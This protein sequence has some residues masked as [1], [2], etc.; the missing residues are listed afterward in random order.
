[1]TSTTPRHEPI[2]I[3]GMACR[4][5]GGRTP[6]EFW[7]FL[8]RGGDG[9]GDIPPERWDSAA[10][11]D[12]DPGVPGKM[13]VK[14]GAFLDDF[15]LFAPGFFGISPR[16][17]QF[18]D[19]QQRLLL[20]VHW[21]A[22]E[23]AGVVPERLAQQQVGVF[24]GIGTSDYNELQ[25]VLGPKGSDAYSGTGGSHAA[26]A[27]R[28]S[29]I[30]GVRG[31]S[32]AVD[33]AC[34]SSLVSVHLA[35][36]S[37][38]GGESDLALASGVTLNF[39]PDVFISLCKARMLS[40]D[41]C[42]KTFDAKANGYARG[43]GCGV[44]V[45]KRLSD[46]Q[47]DGDQILALIRGSAVNHNGRSSGL[48]VPSGP[49]QQEVI[50]TALRN[51]GVDPAEI[52]YVEAH[53]T[54]TALGDP[55]ELNAL[56]AVFAGRSDPL[57]I[58]SV[59]TNTGHLEWAAGAC[60]LTKLVMSMRDGR[61]A[62]SL[63]FDDPNPLIAWDRLPLRVVKETTAWPEGRR[64][65]GV[66]SFGFGGTNAHLVLEAAPA[67]T[68]VASAVER[69]VHILN[70]S[71]KTEDA[72][73]QVALRAAA[74][75]RDLPDGELANYA[76]SGNVGRT[77]Y[78][79]RLT[80]AAAVSA[81]GAVQLA[82]FAEGNPV[83]GLHL[84]HATETPPRLAMLFTGQGSQAPGMGRALFDTQPTF[85]RALE[86]CDALLR[87][88]LEVPL[89]DVLY[90]PDGAGEQALIHQ[91]GYTQPAL[92]ALEWSLAQM[93]LSWGVEPEA[94]LGHSV[95][96]YAAACVAGVFGLADGLKLIAARGRLM[97][98]LPRNGA[99][100]AVRADAARV[101][102]LV[103]AHRDLVAIAT[104]NG[105]TDLTISG[106]RGAVDAIAAALKAD[107]V[108]VHPLRVSH[109]FHSPLMDPI[110]AEFEAIAAGVT[111]APPSMPLISNVTGREATDE[112]CDPHYWSSHIRQAVRFADGL[113]TAFD[114]GCD[115][116][117][118]L[119]PHPVLTTLGRMA[120]GEALW[121]PTL[122]AN[123]SDWR[124]TLDALGRLHLAGAEVDWAG[125]DRDYARRKLPLPN[126]PLDRQRYWF[127]GVAG[128]KGH[129]SL[130][131]LVETMVQSPLI[132][133]TVVSTPLGIA[134]Q[135]YLADHK[136]F[137]EIVVPG[138]AWLA[139]LASATEL[140]GWPACRLDQVYFLQPLVLPE[141]GSR[142]VQAVLTPEGDHDWSCQIVSLP[143]AS[144]PDQAGDDTVVRHVSGRLA[145]LAAGASDRLVSAE[146]EASCPRTMA[147]DELF[148][149]VG[150]SGVALGPAFRWVE[151]LRLGERE[152]F[153]RLVA[154]AAAGPLDG[155]RFH[156]AL[157]D[158]CF[159]VASATLIDGGTPE[160]LLPFSIGSLRLPHPAG[161]GPWRCH[162][163][164][165]G[166]TAWDIRLT[167]ESGVVVATFDRFEM[168]KVPAGALQKHRLTDWLYRPDW[169]PMSIVQPAVPAAPA[170]W[171]LLGDETTL[172]GPLAARLAERGDAVVRLEAA[173]PAAV[174][175]LGESGRLG[176][177]NLLATTAADLP[178]AAPA[179]PASAAPAGPTPASRAEALSVASLRLVQAVMEA[180]VGARLFTVTQHGQTV[181]PGETPDPAQAALWGMTRALILEAPDLHAT[182]ID[183]DTTDLDTLVAELRQPPNEAQ[184]AHRAGQ[185]FV[186]RL[187]R[188]R[189][190]LT[191]PTAGAFRL[192]LAEYGT[193]DQLRLAPMTRRPP[194]EL[195]VEIEVKAASLNF[196][197]VLISLGLMKEFYAERF[198]LTRAADIQL[199]FDCAGVISAVG[200]GVTDLKVGDAV[201]SAAFGGSASFVIAYESVTVRQPEN[202]DF[203][204]ASAIP[205]VFATAC[206]ALSKLAGLRP[207][208]RVLIHAAAGGVGLAAVQVAKAVGAEIF[209]TASP[210]KWDYL[211]SLGIDHVM[212]SR[213]ADF[214]DDILRL[215]GGEGV[216]VVLNSLNGTA[217]DASFRCLKHGGRFVEIGKIG[218]WTT[219]QVAA[220]R[221]DASYH[222]FELGELAA[223]DPPAFRAALNDIR[224]RF[225]TGDFSALP[226][227]VYPVQN[228]VDAY[229]YMQQARQI[230]KV[231][232][233]F[234]SSSPRKL[235]PDSSYL[236]T[237]GL[238]GLGLK[239]AA[240]LVDEGARHLV[241]AGRG[242]PGEAA[243]SAIAA[244]RE[245]GAAVS[246]VA[247][248]VAK[249][250]DVQRLV[251]ACQDLAPLAGVI[252]AAGVLRDAVVANQ[253]A[254]SFAAVM[255]AK[256]LGAWNLHQAT[257]DLP[258]DHFICFSSMAALVGSPGQTNYAAA[259]A[260]VDALI[261][262]RR[263]A[264]LPGLAIDW[265]PWAEVGMAAELDMSRTGIDRID[266]P[267][268]LAVLSGL[269]TLDPASTPV[270]IGVLRVRWDVFRERGLPADYA[271]FVSQLTRQ[272]TA[273]TTRPDDFLARFR[274]TAE[275]ERPTLLQTHIRAALG[276]VLG[277]DA[278]Q[279]IAPTA[280]WM[281]LG[282]DS[283]MMVEVKN[284]L[285]RSFGLTLP[286]EL[287]MADV[288]TAAL[289][290]HVQSKLGDLADRS[291]TPAGLPANAEPPPPD[292]EAA[293]WA[294]MLERVQAIPQAFNTADD[295]RG[296][297]VLIDGRWRTDFASCNYLGF[298]LEPDVMAAIGPAVEK[299]GTHPSWTRAVA[300]P[301]PYAE[302]ERELAK[303]LGCADTLVFPSISLL[304]LGV[305]P[306]LAGFDG[307][308]LKDAAAHHSIHEACLR[309]QPE[310]V[311]W[312]DFRHNDVAD[313][314]E[315][316][317]RYRPERTKIIATDGAYSMGGPYPPLPEYVRL[318]KQHNATVYVDDA[319][320]FGLL[321][322]HPDDA[323]PYGYGGGG[324]VRRFGLGYEA[325][326]ITY[327]AGLS[328]AFSSY[329]AFVTCADQQMK[330]R[331]QTSGPYV[332]SGPTSTAS[333]ATA[334]AGLRLNRTF[335]DVR[336]AQIY[337]LTRR[338]VTEA[339]A[340]GFEV[341]NEGD[342]PIVGV[343]IGAWEAMMTAC[344]LL[345]E[346]DILITPATFPAVPMNRNLVRFSIT[347]A[348]TD[349][350]VSQA[351]AALTAVRRALQTAPETSAPALA[352]AVTA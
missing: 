267:G 43:E 21:E 281:D 116:F 47:A 328:K 176:V 350:E 186:A 107:N 145:P 260:C 322:E 4:Y 325:D 182:A 346:H 149:V 278:G 302:L 164:R 201:M 127:P 79:F 272:P 133:E 206:H 232:L 220:R 214:A 110:L 339:R 13:Y 211:K 141:T 93:W 310:G 86:E 167:D 11:Y 3:V 241:L 130:R 229:R 16:E 142:A 82:D 320:G 87:G 221:P 210:G 294:Q 157:L 159:Q 99:M 175:R 257:Q 222:T 71:A 200:K 275:A 25:A 227:V 41:G 274:A 231:V 183:L 344:R 245:S 269:M 314:A 243:R 19:P 42:C 224:Q 329:A 58:G 10:Y 290:N 205:S 7:D 37:L 98:S 319:H 77:H 209:A 218:I 334:L 270:Q 255:A 60:G 171:L 66:S 94:V 273:A 27:G 296:R 153:A 234:P 293:M 117:L 266:V 90:P 242:A 40:P 348:N 75:L 89:L 121:L 101:Q 288:S 111:F 9:V 341:D 299:W 264:G 208:E 147:A 238:G 85:R 333:L 162:A 59:K 312:L 249:P 335:G 155:Y 137:D 2:A 161:A 15:D 304:H 173:D 261:H 70:L 311:E 24:V 351:I 174:R 239:V 213:N 23:N 279:V 292:L 256:A 143:D 32:L 217:I 263:T 181:Q 44:V 14:R 124:Q 262:G 330:A 8:L 160:N 115:A 134:E 144:L 246:V 31:P 163:V 81:E 268:G 39:S 108:A 83:P 331:L 62:P 100:L 258:L 185:R 204:A 50:R 280:P 301:A 102:P 303:T 129:A 352:E 56:G 191:P 20:E 38:R 342:F 88:E 52:G 138:A 53:G 235:H 72:L 67:P 336:R 168:R 337:R 49:A 22:L 316:L 112:I 251:A 326:R 126:Y 92:F 30:L 178:P 300:S 195:Q 291:D 96:E 125:F 190:A 51:A 48:T 233:S 199:G 198:G 244:L 345:W 132:R 252:H 188:C 189:D 289:A 28:L 197:D 298:D 297:Q 228:A 46:A 276:L 148:E 54:G 223:S 154:P 215:T 33:T 146:V 202:V 69:P 324:I 18:M 327:V 95:G 307:V 65:G 284:R 203:A 150:E 26:A 321:G 216:D 17:A 332:F 265:G 6:T 113:Q 64:I 225:E 313:L 5:P 277:L 36:M 240:Q 226:Q 73:R 172:A 271:S 170:A 305:L 318:A 78:P 55:I 68:F 236:I 165:I 169:R 80:V 308:I 140:M 315:K 12:P 259:N 283:L 180:G 151:S 114:L 118:E 29:Y 237:G 74:A 152:A 340:L 34:S 104:L 120:R 122:Q 248:D 109:A 135:P 250:A 212:N 285:E 192:Q 187:T 103:D 317:A 76:Y 207:G 282:L 63:H 139:M 61:I 349:A 128:A 184:V 166:D 158:A 123:K 1:M 156:P 230:G 179:G 91:T 196:R 105:P 286:V 347:S 247:A 287:M 57:P 45:L 84:G 295:Q 306:V 219:E 343:A 323:L 131:P 254:E 136:V 309:A 253:T 97:Q 193:P 35:V 106:E 338:L 194:G 119:G 177:V